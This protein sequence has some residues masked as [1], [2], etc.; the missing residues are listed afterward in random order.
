ME[1]DRATGR[2]FGAVAVLASLFV[3]V[4]IGVGDGYLAYVI[5]SPGTS[6]AGPCLLV[7]V[8]AGIAA[9]A[10][11]RLWRKHNRSVAR[12]CVATMCVIGALAVWWAWAFAMPAAMAW[13]SS[14]TPNALAALRGLEPE[15]SVCEKVLS[16]SIGPLDAPYERCAVV[17][18]PGATV[19]YSAGR[20]SNSPDRGL[21]FFEGSGIVGTD[22][23][24]RHLA[25]DWY[26]FSGDSSGIL[27]YSFTGGA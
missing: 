9:V 12:L 15:H 21:V 18:P 7:A 5:E 8:V 13:D 24:V 2:Q 11:W 27:G 19:T 16:G 14:A 22:Q 10:G 1:R 4:L 17:G 20:A 6:L 26:A 25:G 23:F 3:A